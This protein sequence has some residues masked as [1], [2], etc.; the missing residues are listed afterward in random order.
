MTT[1]RNIHGRSIQALSTDPTESVAEGQIWYNTGSDTFKSILISEAW[2]SGNPILTGRY[3]GIASGGPTSQSSG[4]V[5]AGGYT[6][7]I[8][9]NVET[10]NG[11]SWATAPSLG[12][13]RDQL[14][15]IVTGKPPAITIPED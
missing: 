7:S 10:W 3:N 1:Y 12:T 14:G 4:M 11:T 15:K 8:V 6:G 2:A 5:I 9:S 13:A